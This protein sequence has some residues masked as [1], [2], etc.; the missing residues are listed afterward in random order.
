MSS[1]WY[2][3]PNMVSTQ[4]IVPIITIILTGQWNSSTNSRNLETARV[5]LESTTALI[6]RHVV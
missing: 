6:L 2:T 5:S 1:T 4:Y 3:A